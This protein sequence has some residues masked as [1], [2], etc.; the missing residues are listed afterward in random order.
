MALAAGLEMAESRLFTTASGKQYFGTERFDRNHNKRLHMHSASGL[1][2]DNFRYS[3]LDYG[4]IMDSAFSLENHVDAYNKVLRLAAFN[5][6]SHNRDDHS[7]NMSFLMDENGNWQLAPAYDLTFSSSSHGLHSTMV[8]GESKN[9]GRKHLIELAEVFSV[10]KPKVIIDQVQRVLS[11]WH[12]YASE[13]GVS[14]S[15]KKMIE[16]ALKLLND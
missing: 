10:K 6:Y 14:E 9:P 5:V 12:D 16:S 1:L 15:S 7:K 11:K 2:H 4:H 8:A 3:N 13:C